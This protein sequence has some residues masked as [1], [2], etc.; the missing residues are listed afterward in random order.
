MTTLAQRLWRAVRGRGYRRNMADSRARRK[1]EPVRRLPELDR[2]AGLWV[3]VKDG[4]VIEAAPS[5]RELVARVRS[6]GERGKGAV[7]Q[8]VPPPSDAIV[9]GVG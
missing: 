4:A 3:A 2:W 8:F 6:M 7:A 5:S 9:I 1:V